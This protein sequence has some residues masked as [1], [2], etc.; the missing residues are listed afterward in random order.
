MLQMIRDVR[1][2]RKLGGYDGPASEATDDSQMY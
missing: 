1:S 2:Q